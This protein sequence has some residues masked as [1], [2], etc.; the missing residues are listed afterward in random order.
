MELC[1]GAA[2]LAFGLNEQMCDTTFGFDFLSG[3]TMASPT[4]RSWVVRNSKR[5][6]NENVF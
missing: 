3:A 6:P 1:D 2:G 5:P 4:T